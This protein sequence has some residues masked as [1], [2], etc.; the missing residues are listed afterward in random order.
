MLKFL[1]FHRATDQQHLILNCYLP[2]TTFQSNPYTVLPLHILFILCHSIPLA[3]LQPNK[4]LSQMPIM[5]FSPLLILSTY[6]IIH[7]SP[8]YS[9]PFHLHHLIQ[10]CPFPY[11]PVPLSHPTTYSS[12]ILS[13][14]LVLP[15]P[16]FTVLPTQFLPVQHMMSYSIP[17]SPFS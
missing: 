2:F 13:H 6:S 12:L 1:P 8:I 17:F 3:K 11:H 14:Y 16:I 7:T 10:L 5:L 9:D 15:L 4:Y